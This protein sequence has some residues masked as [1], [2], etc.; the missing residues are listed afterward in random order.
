MNRGGGF[1]LWK[2]FFLKKTFENMQENDFCVYADAGCSIN[3]YGLNRFE[4]YKNSISTH[5]SGVLSFR[6]DGLDEERY[7]TEEIFKHF[8]IEKSDIIRI[9]GQIMATILIFQKNSIS[10]KLIDDYYNSAIS[11]PN[12]FSDDFNLTNNCER[13]VDNRHDQSILSVL[14]KI[15]NTFEIQDETYADSLEGWNNLIYIKKIP[16]LATRIRI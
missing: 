14:R 8:F 6:M 2:S 7:T 16:F 9:S 4:F 5:N 15:Y 12:L 1:W 3:P 11:K 10:Q 13:F